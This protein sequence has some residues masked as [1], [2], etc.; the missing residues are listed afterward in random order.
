MPVEEIPCD[1]SILKKGDVVHYISVGKGGFIMD[2][3]TLVDDNLYTD[4]VEVR[5]D[6]WKQF[7]SKWFICKV[8]RRGE[9][10]FEK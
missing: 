2:I 7:V 8:E 9:V 5:G 1:V 3:G 6:G 10:I 4:G